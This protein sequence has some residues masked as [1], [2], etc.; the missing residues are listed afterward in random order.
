[1]LK[2]IVLIGMMGSGKT[3]VGKELAKELN[4]TFID[5]DE[6]IEKKYRMSI[7]KIFQT[8]GEFFFRKIEENMSCKFIDGKPGI[9][10]I[11]G[12]GFLNKKIRSNIKKNAISIWI[13]TSLD[14]IYQRLDKSKNKRPLLNYNDLKKS[15]KE[16]YD[17]RIPIYKKADYTIQT[18]SDNKKIIVKK[19][20]KKL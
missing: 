15:I 6:E 13:N 10:S 11:G 2:T 20:I 19:I 18:K 8:K 5:I 16:I 3:S 9:I 1:M 14:R 17:K 12:G 7:P 4:L